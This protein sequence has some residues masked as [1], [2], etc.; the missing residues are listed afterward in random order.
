MVLNVH[1]NHKA[2][3]GRGKKRGGGVEDMGGGGEGSGGRGRL[4]TKTS[5]IQQPAIATAQVQYFHLLRLSCCSVASKTGLA[6]TVAH[7][8]CCPIKRI[9][10]RRFG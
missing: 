3:K 4:C 7:V 10:P 2:H 6:R 5:G 1:R 8:L 9:G